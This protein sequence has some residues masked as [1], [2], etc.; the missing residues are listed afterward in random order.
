MIGPAGM[1][2]HSVTL[3]SISR[4]RDS[5]GQSTVTTATVADFFVSIQ[6]LRGEERILSMQVQP[7]A[8]HKIRMIYDSRVNAESR[9]LFGSRTF[10][11]LGPPINI[12]ERS[13]ELELTCKELA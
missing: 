13:R 8:T 7:E 3:I 1:R 11:V 4:T 6:P 10:E 2:Q 5:F 9:L 12:D